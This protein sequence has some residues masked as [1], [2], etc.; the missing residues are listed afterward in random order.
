MC[1]PLIA[2]AEGR[3][4]LTS[5]GGL[6]KDPTKATPDRDGLRPGAKTTHFLEPLLDVNNYFTKT[7]SGQTLEKLT[8]KGW[9]LQ[10]AQRSCTASVSTA[11]TTPTTWC[12]RRAASL[13]ITSLHSRTFR[14]ASPA[15]A[16]S[17]RCPVPTRASLAD[18]AIFLAPT[19]GTQRNGPV[20]KYVSLKRV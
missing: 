1:V 10:V 17:S 12:G 15:T 7:A 19:V 18:H 8:Q 20:R 2:A 9:F 16:G 4:H 11:A 13:R 5:I 6:H 14:T 3:P